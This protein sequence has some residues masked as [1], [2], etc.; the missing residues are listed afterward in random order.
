M[1]LRNL[2]EACEG[3]TLD[4]ILEAYNDVTHFK[5]QAITFNLGYLSPEGPGP[6]RTDLLGLVVEDP[7]LYR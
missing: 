7:R 1:L 3:I 2:Q 5:E 6:G 4:N